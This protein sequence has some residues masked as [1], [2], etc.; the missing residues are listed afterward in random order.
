MTG[1]ATTKIYDRL[2]TLEEFLDD[3]NGSSTSCGRVAFFASSVSRI[4]ENREIRNIPA[5]TLIYFKDGGPTVL[6][7]KPFAETHNLFWP[8]ED[9][10]KSE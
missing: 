5:T 6:I 2:I 4:K 9:T 10:D 1:W 3:P 7:K 8:P